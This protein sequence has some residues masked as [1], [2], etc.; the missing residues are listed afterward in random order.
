MYC[1]QC[2]K[3]INDGSSYC[4]YCGSGT[5]INWMTMFLAGTI[6]LR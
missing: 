3:E 6:S 1:K 4:S 2:G 5:G